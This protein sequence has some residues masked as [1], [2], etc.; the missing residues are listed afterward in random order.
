MEWLLDCVMLS[1]YMGVNKRLSSILHLYSYLTE[2]SSLSV[3]FKIGILET[4]RN[5]AQVNVL[6]FLIQKL[7]I[8]FQRLSENRMNN[9]Y[10]MI[11]KPQLRFERQKLLF[12]EHYSTRKTY[13]EIDLVDKRQTEACR[14]I[15]CFDSAHPKHLD[16]CTLGCRSNLS[17]VL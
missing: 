7:W 16:I 12:G 5:L 2:I 10:D 13:Q 9:I 14:I 11:L 4:R 17:C 3:A 15:D 8:G 6:Q 1:L